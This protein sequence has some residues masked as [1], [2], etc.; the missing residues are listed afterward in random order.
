M[1]LFGICDVIAAFGWLWLGLVFVLLVWVL[2][3]VGLFGSTFA[4][5]DFVGLW[6]SIV[7]DFWCLCEFWILGGCCLGV[8]WWFDG[9]WWACVFVSEFFWMVVGGSGAEVLV[10]EFSDFVM[11]VFKGLLCIYGGYLGGFRFSGGFLTAVLLGVV[12]GNME[13]LPVACV[14]VVFWWFG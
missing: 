14:G 7:W 4:L 2:F 10:S 5:A 1:L 3:P 6:A 9:F 12:W 13:F 8:G 11:V